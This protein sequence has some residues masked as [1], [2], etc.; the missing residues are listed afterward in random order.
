MLPELR[1]RSIA[2]RTQHT[3][4]HERRELEDLGDR[5]DLVRRHA[6]M[7]VDADKCHHH[8]LG[9][10]EYASMYIIS[11]SPTVWDH[12]P[13]LRTLLQDV[14]E[15]NY[16][17]VKSIRRVLANTVCYMMMDDHEVSDDW[18]LDG[19]IVSSVRHSRYGRWLVANARANCSIFQMCGNTGRVNQPLVE[20]IRSFVD[21]G[22]RETELRR[23]F[24][25]QED[26]SGLLSSE[27][28]TASDIEE[29]HD[30]YEVALRRYVSRAY[31][32]RGYST[33]CATNP[34]VLLVDTRTRRS[35]SRS[36][37]P[38]LVNP[39]ERRQID[40]LLNTLPRSFQSPLVVL[41]PAPMFGLPPVESLQSLT[42]DLGVAGGRYG[43]DREAWSHNASCF[44]QF[45][46][47]LASCRDK[48]VVCSGDVHYGFTARA[49]LT[50][51]P[52]RP[53]ADIE[54]IVASRLSSRTDF[55]QLTSSALRNQPGV[56]ERAFA[57]AFSRPGGSEA[58]RLPGGYY[59]AHG[60]VNSNSPRRNFYT[61]AELLN[62]FGLVK[63]NWPS[64]S[65][66]VTH[67]LFTAD[68]DMEWEQTI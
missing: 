15:R 56:T 1:P 64:V 49:V 4:T 20:S 51:S 44:E 30:A 24:W 66:N 32:L 29:A 54:T 6:G 42:A 65:V 48:I 52:I 34:P 25:R 38:G 26:E 16:G 53:G 55:V 37:P 45:L 47:L 40:T 46:L 10:G 12:P 13:R 5:S 50:S 31:Q 60:T 58:S 33:L 8:L 11:W 21:A 18:P 41:S 2:P 39:A 57:S 35:L 14:R 59:L 67:K 36:G 23:E 22:V 63:M 68:G 17:D 28:V 62:N 61:G 3:P 43:S 27:R 7:T 9:F 19:A